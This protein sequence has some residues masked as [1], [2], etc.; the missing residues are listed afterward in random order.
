MQNRTMFCNVGL[1]FMAIF[2]IN[3]PKGLSGTPVQFV[4]NA[5]I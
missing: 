4:I 5:I 1:A 2:A 3:S